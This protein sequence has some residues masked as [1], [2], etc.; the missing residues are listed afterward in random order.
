MELL[1]SLS[2]PAADAATAAS[3]DS[4]PPAFAGELAAEE[5]GVEVKDRLVALRF[6][7]LRRRRGWFG[8]SA[9]NPQEYQRETAASHLH[10]VEHTG[11]PNTS[12]AGRASSHAWSLGH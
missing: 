8:S 1:F 11:R 10:G 3:E 2:A 4:G 5:S 12:I 6:L 9:R 7:C